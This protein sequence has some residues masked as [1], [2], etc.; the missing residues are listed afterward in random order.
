MGLFINKE[1]Y[2]QI[3]LSTSEQKASN[4][5]EYRHDAMSEFREFQETINRK[6]THSVDAVQELF[7][8]STTTL[9]EQNMSLVASVENQCSNQQTIL[10]NLETLETTVLDHLAKINDEQQKLLN[11]AK[12]DED[13]Q[14]AIFAQLTVQDQRTQDLLAKITALKNDSEQLKQEVIT[15]NKKL[16]EKIEVQDVYHQTVMERIQAQEA[17]TF[18][19]NRQLDNLKAVIFERIADLADKIEYQSKNTIKTLS[20]FFIKPVKS[21]SVETKK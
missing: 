19:M 5:E 9:K 16:S 10:K 21:S 18:K 20:G 4:Q 17:V 12:L 15:S 1:L 8:K 3:H 6:L 11:V 13:Q 14:H 2:P 7:Q